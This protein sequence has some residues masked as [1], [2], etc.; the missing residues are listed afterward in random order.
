[1]IGPHRYNQCPLRYKSVTIRLQVIFRDLSLGLLGDHIGVNESVTKWPTE[2][3]IQLLR[4]SFLRVIPASDALSSQ[5]YA[6]LF[7]AFPETRLLFPVDIEELKEK[8][9]TMLATAVDLL[10]DRDSF[11]HACRQIGQRHVGYGTETAHYGILGTILIEA[12]SDV[13]QGII[14]ADELSIW[15]RFYELV[16]HEMIIG[17]RQ[18]TFAPQSA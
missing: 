7:S 8:L 16:A 12:L 6:R 14:S 9:V 1:M 17:S 10:G 15:G 13:G 5:V 11:Q 18:T 4:Q 3:E 2:D